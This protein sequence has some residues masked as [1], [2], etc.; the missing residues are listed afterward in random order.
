MTFCYPK[1]RSEYWRF[2]WS[3]LKSWAICTPLFAIERSAYCIDCRKF[4]TRL[5]VCFW[6]LPRINTFDRPWIWSKGFYGNNHR[7]LVGGRPYFAAY[8]QSWREWLRFR[9]R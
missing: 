8:K 4:A 5:V 7:C 3:S 9:W 2:K 1:P 6:M